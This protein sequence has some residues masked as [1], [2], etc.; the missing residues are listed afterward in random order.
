MAKYISVE[1]FIEQTKGHSYDIDKVAGVQCVDGIKQ[2]NVDV[3]GK[4]DFTCGNGYAY[5]L[6]TNYGTNGV[7]KY[8]DKFSYNQAKKGDWIIWNKNS[9]GAPK[10][11]VAML[12]KKVSNNIVNAYGQ[13][14]NGKKYFNFADV[15]TDGILGVLRPKI[16]L[17]QDFL[18]PRGYWKY[19]D[20]DKRIGEVASF[21]YKTFPAYTDKSALGNY[22]GKNLLKSIKEFQKRTG[23]EPDGNIGPKTY[24]MLQ[25]Y[26][27]KY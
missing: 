12:Y 8:F 22:F 14:Q 6:W 18:P 7:E 3:Y 17:D 23:L 4:A 24:N 11:H 19:G 13:N 27:F 1:K 10:S 16:Y 26:G 25:K 5:G 21:M 20:T 15:N 2:F 9:K